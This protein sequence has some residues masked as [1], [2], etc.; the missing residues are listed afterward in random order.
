MADPVVIREFSAEQVGELPAW[1]RV[2]ENPNLPDHEQAVYIH[3]EVARVGAEGARVDC[4]RRYP[5]GNKVGVVATGFEATAIFLIDVHQSGEEAMSSVTSPFS[6]K[7]KGPN[8]LVRECERGPFG[9]RTLG[10]VADHEVQNP[11]ELLTGILDTLTERGLEAQYP[12]VYYGLNHLSAKILG[13]G[14]SADAPRPQ[15][16]VLADPGMHAETAGEIKF[17]ENF[18][19]TLESM[20]LLDQALLRDLTCF[21]SVKPHNIVNHFKKARGTTMPYHRDALNGTAS[22]MIAPES[23]GDPYTP[24]RIQEEAVISA[25]EKKSID[26]PYDL[27]QKELGQIKERVA[28]AELGNLMLNTLNE[29]ERKLLLPTAE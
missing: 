20:Q 17:A 26:V 25:L 3:A 16:W 8:V 24:W 18:L 21:G 19:A 15:E 12:G 7:P 9:R 14:N 29:A 11:Q 6:G 28:A 2:V 27:I 23:V 5:D 1:F 22:F 10:F 4:E 13:A